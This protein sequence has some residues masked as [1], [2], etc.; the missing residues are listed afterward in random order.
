MKVYSTPIPA[1]AYNWK[2]GFNEL[3]AREKAHK[4]QVAQWLRD[5]GYTGPHT[6]RVIGFGVG[7]GTAQYMIGDK[8][9][10][11][12]LIHLPYGDAYQYRDVGFL[13][14]SEI[15]RRSRPLEE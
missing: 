4:K 15:V 3:I 11:G 6:G 2:A 1:P 12:I 9:K 14:K 13:P 10:G 5:N 7:D 8:G